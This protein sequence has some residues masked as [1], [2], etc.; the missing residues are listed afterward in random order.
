MPLWYASENESERSLASGAEPGHPQGATSGVRGF[1][2]G[3]R[4]RNASAFVG[5][6]V[7]VER[8]R[9]LGEMRSATS[10]ES[11][12]AVPKIGTSVRVTGE[13]KEK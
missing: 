3:K 6:I 11:R 13:A 10:D 5:S 1:E 7:N 9:R 12:G 2:W 4:T 8:R